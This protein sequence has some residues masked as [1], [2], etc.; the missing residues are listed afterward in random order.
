MAQSAELNVRPVENGHSDKF[1][2]VQ[3]D[4]TALPPEVQH[5]IAIYAPD[6]SFEDVCTQLYQLALIITHVPS[7]ACRWRLSSTGGR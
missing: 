3:L 6:R 5:K 1:I 4:E 7:P 2:Y